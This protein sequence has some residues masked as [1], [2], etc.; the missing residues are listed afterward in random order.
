MTA[1]VGDKLYDMSYVQTEPCE[2]QFSTFQD[3]DG[4]HVYWHSSAHVLGAALE[5]LYSGQLGHGP[6]IASGFFYDCH[7]PDGR[8]VE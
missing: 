5:N 6:A 4:K 2:V 7:I 3:E 1:R 8:P